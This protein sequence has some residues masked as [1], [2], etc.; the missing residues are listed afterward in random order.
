MRGVVPSRDHPAAQRPPHR[1]AQRGAAQGR[2]AQG[3]HAVRGLIRGRVRGEPRDVRGE[4]DDGEGEGSGAAERRPSGVGGGG[5]GGPRRAPR[6]SLERVEARIERRVNASLGG[7]PRTPPPRTPR[8]P[9]PRRTPRGAGGAR[10]GGDRRGTSGFV[11]SARRRVGARRGV[12]DAGE[13]RSVQALNPFATDA[14]D[15]EDEEASSAASVG[16]AE[17][18][19]FVSDYVAVGAEADAA[20]GARPAE[21]EGEGEDED[22]ASLGRMDGL[23]DAEAALADEDDDL[24]EQAAREAAAVAARRR[25]GRAAFSA[26]G[27]R[28]FFEPAREQDTR[29][30]A[31]VDLRAVRLALEDGYWPSVQQG[32]CSGCWAYSTVQVIAD[33]KLIG[34]GH[35]PSPSPYY[36]LSCDVARQRV[37]HRQ[38]GH[39]VRMDPGAAARYPGRG[40]LPTTASDRC[41]ET[42]ETQRPRA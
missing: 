36:L 32:A 14:D 26:G 4:P 34:T 20:G 21:E 12:V 19:A 42:R 30:P 3:R 9:P 27:G 1:G 23:S 15:E 6:R 24:A 8:T 13:A 29:R 22:E 28:V 35:R 10:G 2:H 41:M 39:G 16:G 11:V 37:Q 7:T 25:R 33:S 5:R 31:D 38:H 17:A 40:G 18:E